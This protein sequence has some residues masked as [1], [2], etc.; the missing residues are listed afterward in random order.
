MPDHYAD[1][2]YGDINR[3]KQLEDAQENKEFDRDV[4]AYRRGQKNLTDEER[5]ERIKDI[6]A[7]RKQLKDN[8]LNAITTTTNFATDS[9]E[10]AKKF[11]DIRNPLNWGS[12]IGALGI[13]AI[14][15]AIPKT[16]QE[17][18]AEL[19]ELKSA[20]AAYPALKLAKEIPMV[21]SGID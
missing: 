15:S 8:L 12:N 10:D 7:K 1:D 21:A 11:E 2:I 20:G 14:D 5:L 19:V 3:K 9:I 6:T 16:P 18:Q 4:E 17:L 13:R